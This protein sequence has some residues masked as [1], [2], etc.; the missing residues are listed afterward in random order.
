MNLTLTPEDRIRLVRAQQALLSPLDHPT[1]EDWILNA[2]AAIEELIGA[3]KSM[4][5][6]PGDGL[7][8]IS[9]C[10]PKNAVKSYLA[11]VPKVWDEFSFSKQLAVHRVWSR[12]L[13]YADRLKDYYRSAYYCELMVPNR[14]FHGVGMAVPL[15]DEADLMKTVTLIFHHDNP[16]CPRF[17][18]RV[19]EMMRL[20]YPALEAGLRVHKQ[21]SER[22]TEINRAI[23]ALGRPIRVCSDSG[24]IL[25]QSPSLSRLLEEDYQSQEIERRIDRIVEALTARSR[26]GALE[27]A[28]PVRATVRTNRDLYHL[29]GCVVKSGI[30]SRSPSVMIVVETSEQV[31]PGEAE[32]RDRF[33]LT[34]QEVRVAILISRRGSNREIAE[35]LA[36][37]EHTARHHTE[38]VMSKLDVHSRKD[39]AARLLAITSDRPQSL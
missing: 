33:G 1:H 13:V 9:S 36:I 11:D 21:L 5:Q 8:I 16:K 10:Y 23:D 7:S 4:A 26:S 15:E 17:D 18:D 32:L 6:Y 30:F 35:A 31:L 12:E 19:L 2:L 27:P 29:N 38:Q 20:L 34:L 24:A 22:R 28:M 3:D 39:V 14:A 37:S 25:H